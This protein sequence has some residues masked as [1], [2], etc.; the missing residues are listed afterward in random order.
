MPYR[1][2]LIGCGRIGLRHAMEISRTGRLEAVCDIDPS[3]AESFAAKFN[4]RAYTSMDSLLKKEQVDVLSICT[5]NG[6]H[7]EQSIAGLKRGIHVVCEKPMC[8]HSPEGKAMIETAEMAGRRLFIV[9]QNR[10]NEPV[11]IL[12]SLLDKGALGKVFSF[13]LNCYWCRPPEYYSDNWRGSLEL[14]GGTL[15]TQFSHFIDLLYWFLGDVTSVSGQRGNYT[16][17]GLIEFEDTGSAILMMASGAMGTINYTISSHSRN[18]EGSFTVF[19]EKGTVKIGGQYLNTLEHFEVEGVAKPHLATETQANDYGFYQGSMSNHH[20]V[21][22]NI[23]SS[24]SD[25]SVPYLDAAEA[26]KT[27]QIIE[28]IYRSSPLATPL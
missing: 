12:K 1:F 22:D 27:V 15:F 13:Q 8:L 7:S 6:Y 2:A 3:R 16:H 4:C 14:D 26:L 25:S 11:A 17:R 18:M 28:A 20:L 24:L 19:G 5:P 23:V 9:K 21:Y 10:Y